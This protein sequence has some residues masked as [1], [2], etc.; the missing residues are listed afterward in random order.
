VSLEGLDASSAL[1]ASAGVSTS[2]SDKLPHLNRAVQRPGHEVSSIRCKCN[3]I[4]RVLVAIRTLETLDEIPI[5]G[6]P[7]AD[8]LVKGTGGDVLGVGGDGDSGHTIFNAEGQ[9]VLTSLNIPEAHS[10]VATAGG[11][12]APITSEVE[13]VD[14]LLMTSEAIPDRPVGDIPDLILLE[15]IYYHKMMHLL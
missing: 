9:D 3:R 8:A 12:G 2:W 10:A 6:I 7:H 1:G 14:V 5:S 4:Y 11:D 15:C 13:R